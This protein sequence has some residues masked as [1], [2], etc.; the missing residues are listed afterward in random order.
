M[1]CLFRITPLTF[2][3]PH[4]NRHLIIAASFS[5]HITPS[6]HPKQ[7]NNTYPHPSRQ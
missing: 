7:L 6:I 5:P 4:D 2:T 1:Y 3:K